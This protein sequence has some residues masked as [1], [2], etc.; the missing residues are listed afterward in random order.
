M[1]DTNTPD[2]VISA[3]PAPVTIHAQYLKDVSFENPNAPETLKTGK[4]GPEMDVNINLGA[5]EVPEENIPDLYEVTLMLS[6]T[7]KKDDKVYFIAEIQYAALVSLSGLP[8]QQH[9]PMLFI[10]VPRMMFPFARQILGDLTGNGG[11]PP[12][13]LNPVDFQG[14]YLERFAKDLEDSKKNGKAA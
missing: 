6:A 7:A 2:D 8:E 13:L 12:L 4:S 10:E 14:M 1:S 3:K 11:Y 9:H 5:R